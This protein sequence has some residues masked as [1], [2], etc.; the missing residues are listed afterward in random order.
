METLLGWKGLID[1]D[2][3]K[4]VAFGEFLSSILQDRN[5]S[6]RKLSKQCGIDHATISKI[7][8]GKRKINLKHLEKLAVGLDLELAI[9]M[10]AA[11]YD[12]ETKKEKSSDIQVA[13]QNIQQLIESSNLYHG[14]FTLEK[15]E[16][17]IA[18]YKNYSQTEEGK[19]TILNHFNEKLQKTGG[20]GPYIENLK[21]MFHRFIEEKGSSL[22]IGLM[23]GALLY[24]IVTTDLLPDYLF[25]IGYLDDA[26]VAQ[27]VSQ[28][29][30][31][32]S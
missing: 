17:E 4:N 1:L 32:R 15:M 9:L 7:M 20:I 2:D 25:P 8:N 11:G 24:F 12:M 18:N 16:Q 3:F 29:L 21:W 26:L 31:I 13:L 19:N 5:L 30:N 6:I 14:N 23:G 22:Q 27:T 28:Q 10:K